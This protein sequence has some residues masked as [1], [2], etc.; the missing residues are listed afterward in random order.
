MGLHSQFCK[1]SFDIL[2]LD[3]VRRVGFDELLE[4]GDPAGVSVMSF[5][6]VISETSYFFQRLKDGIP[7]TDRLRG[8]RCCILDSAAFF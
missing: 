6:G 3:F 4:A 2:H 1:K 7:R 8:I 5:P